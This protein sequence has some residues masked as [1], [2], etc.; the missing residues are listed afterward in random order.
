M[1]DF[2]LQNITDHPFSNLNR[3]QNFPNLG[4]LVSFL[5]THSELELKVTGGD[6]WIL[7]KALSDVNILDTQPLP[8][9]S[10][11]IKLGLKLMRVGGTLKWQ[12]SP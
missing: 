6:R 3:V 4:S 5:G 8:S 2:K 1:G 11:S 12:L 10:S 7:N 9:S